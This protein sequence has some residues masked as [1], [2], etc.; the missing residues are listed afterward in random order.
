M[1]CKIAKRPAVYYEYEEYP[2]C[3]R[4]CECNVFSLAEGLKQYDT[5]EH[6]AKSKSFVVKRVGL[7]LGE[8]IVGIRLLLLVDGQRVLVECKG[9]GKVEKECDFKLC[10]HEHIIGIT[11]SFTDT[12]LS[13][14]QLVTSGERALLAESRNG[15]ASNTKEYDLDLHHKA[16]IGIKCT[17]REYLESFW[18]YAG[19]RIDLLTDEEIQ[20]HNIVKL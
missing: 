3:L 7:W 8:F 1:G 12:A 10:D 5:R 11:A 2:E 20:Q 9:T 18:I 13:T 16:V 15:T 19:V 17:C 14:L 6:F 4:L